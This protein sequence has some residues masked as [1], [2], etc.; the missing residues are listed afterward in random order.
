MYF[1]CWNSNIS[2]NPILLKKHFLNK[3]FPSNISSLHQ[4][5]CLSTDHDELPGFFLPRHRHTAT[6]RI[7]TPFIPVH[8]II[9]NNETRSGSVEMVLWIMLPI[10][11]A[12]R[13]KYIVRDC[14]CFLNR[15][16]HFGRL[17]Y[18]FCY[19]Y[20]LTIW[21]FA[22]KICVDDFV[23]RLRRIFNCFVFDCKILKHRTDLTIKPSKKDRNYF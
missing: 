6:H 8:P 4:Q 22:L 15:I 13:L 9:V 18:L 7:T 20:I 10:L 5:P 11:K 12:L 1:K 19:A 3:Y 2:Y 14:D 21:W 16:V 23:T 17:L